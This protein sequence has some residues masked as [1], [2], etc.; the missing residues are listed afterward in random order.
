MKAVSTFLLAATLACE[1]IFPKAATAETGSSQLSEGSYAQPELPVGRR[2][3]GYGRL[4][5]NDLFGDKKDRWRTGSLTSSRVWGYHWNGTLPD[6][7]GELLELRLQGQII[8]PSRLTR[9]VPSDRRYA[10]AISL[11]LHSHAQWRG[12]EVSMGADIV[13]IGDQTGLSSFQRELHELVGADLPAAGILANQIGNTIRPTFVAEF[14]QDIQLENSNLRPFAEVRAGDE[15]LVRIGADLTFGGGGGELL[16]R[17]S[18]TGQRYRVLFN[19]EPRWNFIIGGDVAYVEDSVY[20]PDNIGVDLKN[21][22]YRLRAGVNWQG[23]TS[24]VF[25]G[26]TYLSEEF[27]NQP[28]G[29]LVGS[30]RLKFEF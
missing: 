23:A 20:L 8:T 22:R 5:T 27:E 3:L 29:Q 2:Y 21:N 25:Y 17:E 12:L 10:T 1:L 18:V 26:L 4:F 16:V 28:E 13:V 14:G 19:E 6:R 11:G 15:T 30:V 9:Y 24:S 7:L